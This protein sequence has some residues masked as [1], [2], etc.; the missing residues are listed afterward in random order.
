MR[1][2]AS[3]TSGNVNGVESL[4]NRLAAPASLE[5]A[6]FWRDVESVDI[7]LIAAVGGKSDERD[8][9][10]LWRAGKALRGVYLFLNRVTD[11]ANVDKG[12]MRNLAGSDIWTLTLRL[13]ATYCGSYTFT[14]IPQDASAEQLA[15]LGTRRPPFPGQPDP[16]HKTTGIKVRGR[17]ESVLA[18]DKAPAQSEW[19]VSANARGE[20]TTSCLLLAGR[21]RRVRLY[22]PEVP[23]ATPLGLLVLPDAES[24]F[25]HVGLLSAMDVAIASGRISPLAVLGIDNL[26]EKDRATILGGD[27][28]LIFDLAR[29]VPQIRANRS[30][31]IWAGRSHTVFCGQSLGGVSA[32]MGALYA[33]EIFG[34]VIV[35][36]PSMWWTPDKAR[37][38]FMFHEGD[39]SWVSQQVL[40]A[41]PKD[42]RIRLCVGTLEGATVPHVQALHKALTT[43]GVESQLALYTG[44]HDYAWWRGAIID[45]LAEL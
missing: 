28:M 39:E 16:L 40:A 18:L 4:L 27:S 42:V 37:R 8:V 45:G 22:I 21:E 29:L 12:M 20:L 11:K 13:P 26:D 41:P 9:T 7:P 2:R 31:R 34:A 24:W 23:D 32:L 36:S 3:D 14:E 30:D 17:E 15:Q 33:P 10:F 19:G 6:Q 5:R 1:K 38:P 43:V 25:D 44:G 35:N